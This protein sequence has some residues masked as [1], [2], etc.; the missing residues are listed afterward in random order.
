MPTPVLFIQGGSEGAYREDA[1]LAK[2][3]GQELGAGYD[4]RYPAMPNESEPDL[5]A[6]KARILAELEAMGP[7]AVLVGHSIGASVVIKLLTEDAPSLAGVFLI[8]TPFW[9]QH[10]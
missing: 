7:G 9:Y 1:A 4:V 6:W 2:S 5:A 3:L 10:D 8:A